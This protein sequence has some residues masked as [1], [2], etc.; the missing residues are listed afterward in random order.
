M[1]EYEVFLFVCLSLVI[2][3]GY[4]LG[5][6][7]AKTRTEQSLLT[8]DKTKPTNQAKITPKKPAITATPRDSRVV[9]SKAS[10]SKL[11]HY[12]YCGGAKQIKESNKIYFSSAAAA[13]VAGYTLAA[14]CTP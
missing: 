14:N 10:K 6:A 3:I 1:Y 11:Y 9:V 2:G 7:W 8:V 13:E 12:T 5:H 4:N